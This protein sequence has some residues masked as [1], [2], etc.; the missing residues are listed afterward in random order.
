MEQRIAPRN[1]LDIF[2]SV[3]ITFIS[4][5]NTSQCYQF[6]LRNVSSSGMCV[7]VSEKSEVMNYLK[8]GDTLNIKYCPIDS[9]H[10]QENIKTEIKH[11]TYIPKKGGTGNGHYYV[12]LSIIKERTPVTESTNFLSKNSGNLKKS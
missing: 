8:T 7:L 10:P 11:I 12:G 3:E 9:T 2:Y 1:Y 4:N 5:D 6:K